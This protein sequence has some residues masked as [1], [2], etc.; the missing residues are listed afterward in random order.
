MYRRRPVPMAKEPPGETEGYASCTKWEPGA[1]TRHCYPA[2]TPGLRPINKDYMGS[3]A[4]LPGS[5]RAAS[6][7]SSI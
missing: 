4:T 1:L 6:G 3:H 7:I 5:A 2:R